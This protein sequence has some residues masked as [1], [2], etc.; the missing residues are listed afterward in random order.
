MQK[1]KLLPMKMQWNGTQKLAL[2]SRTLKSKQKS[3]KANTQGL[4]SLKD[5]A[6]QASIRRYERMETQVREPN[7][8]GHYFT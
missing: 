8:T 7:V 3:T 4:V 2:L 6:A 1:R 5:K